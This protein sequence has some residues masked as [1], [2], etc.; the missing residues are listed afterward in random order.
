[1]VLSAT[2]SR[3]YRVLGDFLV[4]TDTLVQNVLLVF[5]FLP[6]FHWH[7]ACLWNHTYGVVK[8]QTVV[9]IAVRIRTLSVH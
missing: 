3:L 8:V 1:V 2:L 4:S 6:S 7:Y 9:T 5:W